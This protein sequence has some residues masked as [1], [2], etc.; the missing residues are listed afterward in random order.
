MIAPETP[1]SNGQVINTFIGTVEVGLAESEV[2]SY[3]ET[4]M[5]LETEDDL[6]AG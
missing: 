2:V 6:A 5:K 1:V 3:Y 4:R